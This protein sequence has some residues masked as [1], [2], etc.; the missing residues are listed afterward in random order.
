MPA[1]VLQLIEPWNTVGALVAFLLGLIM[2]SFANVVGYRVPRGESVVQPRSR[3]PSCL[4]PLS[5]RELVPVLS[6]V[7][8]GGRCRACGTLIA[9]RYPTVELIGGSLFAA[10][11]L[12]V[13]EVPQAF[14]W[15]V[16]WTLLLMV[17]VS[18]ITS[19]RVPNPFS[20]SGAIVVV[21]L[22][23]AVDIHS[24][25]STLLGAG[26]ALG[27]LLLLY[28]VSGG[29]LG[30]GDVK[31]YIS[32]GAMLGAGGALGSLFVA[33]LSGSV[34][35]LALRAAGLQQRRAH[36]PFVPHILVGVVVSVYFG[37]PLMHWYVATALGGLR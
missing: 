20:Y 25:T 35:G 16:F 9:L 15:G 30:M 5:G 17:T 21:I 1:E 19:M 4:H 22:V 31:L 14:V 3:C 27:V 32:I 28:F 23:V 13:H 8:L 24:L 36:M 18:D 29:R 26:T 6:W 10:T 12:Q 7:L 11:W 33:S 37:A 2:G 34:V